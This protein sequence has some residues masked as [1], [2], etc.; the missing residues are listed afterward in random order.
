M[1]DDDAITLDEDDP[2]E[3]D[4]EERLLTRVRTLQRAI[5]R[6]EIVGQGVY[7]DVETGFGEQD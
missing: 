5:S 4:E 7:G 1:P 3:G 6:L 2:F